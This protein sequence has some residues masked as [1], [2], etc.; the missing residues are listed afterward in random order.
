MS[1]A[2]TA[3]GCYVVVLFAMYLLQRSLMYFP[4]DAMPSPTASSLPDMTVERLHTE[5]N[6]D[7][8]AWYRPPSSPMQP[9]IVYLHGNGGHIGYRGRRVRPYLD[10][11]MGVLL[12][13]YR[14]Y[15]SNP[16]TPTEEGLYADG[17]AAL[18]FLDRRG[19]PDRCR[20][21]YGESLGTAVAIR[22]AAEAAA[23]DRPVTAV[24]LEA[25]LSSVADVAAYHYPIF[26]VRWLIKDRFDALS[27]IGDVEA[28]VFVAHGE[29]DRVVPMRFGRALFDA[30]R[31]PKEG[32]WIAE[33]RHEDLPRFGLPDRVIDFLRRRVA[34]NAGAAERSD[35][36]IRDTAKPLNACGV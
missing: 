22:M 15:G 5:D 20:V 30:A 6:L 36:N 1:V 27:T 8:L 18:R 2:V 4:D 19:V 17:R 29:L 21:L 16:G 26:P 12:V 34:T 13:E 28:P 33:G 31:E 32:W 7:L 10:A 25:P 14:G 3:L 11:G 23:E 9:V 35:A 24:V